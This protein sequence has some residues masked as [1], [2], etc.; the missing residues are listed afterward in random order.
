M[1][2]RRLEPPGGDAPPTSAWLADDELDLVPLAH[3]ICRR[4][5]DE[6]PD[7]QERYGKPGELWCVHD[8][9]CLLYWA[10][11]AASGFLDMQREVGWLASVLEARD[12]PIDRL[13]RNLQ[14]GAEVVRGELNKTQG[15]QVSDALT[16]AAE[17]VRSRGTFLD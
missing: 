2:Q 17:F 1:N 10:C 3:E 5:R 13:V 4:Y 14:I 16:D 12:F 8:N 7:E 11:E 15:E 9:Q 6:F